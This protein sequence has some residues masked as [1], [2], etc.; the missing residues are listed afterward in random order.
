MRQ[1]T[2]PA[3][4]W[5]C[6]F[7][8]CWLKWKFQWIVVVQ[9]LSCV[10]HFCD[11]MDC[12]TPGFPVLYYLLEFAQTHVHWVNDAIQPSH[13]LSPPSPPVFSLS[14]HQGLFQKAQWI[15]MLKRS[16]ANSEWVP[17]VS[18]FISSSCKHLS[19]IAWTNWA[20]TRSRSMK[21]SPE[22]VLSKNSPFL[23]RRTKALDFKDSCQSPYFWSFF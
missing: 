21:Q 7:S 6:I 14:Q 11:P 20:T 8:R 9:S 5:H 13:P 18:L 3:E 12:I 16:Q 15:E 10:L 2:V 17:M 1:I 22:S 19:F 4:D 23:F